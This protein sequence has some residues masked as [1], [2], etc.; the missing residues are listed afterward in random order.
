VSKLLAKFVH[1]V[2]RKGS[3][4]NLQN[5]MDVVLDNVVFLYGYIQQKDVFER[6]YQQYLGHRLL[7]GTVK[8]VHKEKYMIATLKTKCGYQ[9]TN[10]LEGM[11]TDVDNSRT[12]TAKFKKAHKKIPIDLSVTVC[13]Q[14]FWPDA[15]PGSY[16]LPSNLQSVLDKFT[17]YY[18]VENKRRSLQ[19]RMD[20]G[21]AVCTVQFSPKV[22]RDVE[23]SSYMMMILMLFNG[24]PPRQP[25]TFKEMQTLLK[26]P[27][28][29]LASHLLSLSHPK[30][31]I[32]LK[33]PNTRKLE[34]DHMFLINAQYFSNVRLV[35]VPVYVT[36]A[37]LFQK[38]K[39]DD[40]DREIERRHIL[41]AAIVRI[42]KTRKT[43]R[44]NELIA[45][46]VEQ[47]KARFLP[48]PVDIKKRIESLIETDYMK[49]D[50]NDRNIYLYLA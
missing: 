29:D 42:M 49:R 12:L 7:L 44:H 5:D 46:V 2:L 39:K 28:Q 17:A 40:T 20:E 35:R 31:K 13:T 10:K 26:V 43:Y 14:A 21:T 19:Y 15:T 48:K 24:R 41:D 6:I 16:S 50:T 36:A 23:L 1:E 34:D 3:N 32:L 47:V 30:T 18:Q 38:G 27:Q 4:I 25:M 8:S 45:E 9:W 22:T 11:F 33:K 37:Q